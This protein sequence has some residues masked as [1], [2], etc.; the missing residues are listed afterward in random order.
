[1]ACTSRRPPS[2]SRTAALTDD[3]SVWPEPRRSTAQDGASGSI[4]R[5]ARRGGR[6]QK[7]ERPERWQGQDLEPTSALPVLGIVVI[8]VVEII[9]KVEE[10]VTV[11]RAI[12]TGSWSG[13][14][15]TIHDQ[16]CRC[17]AVGWPRPAL[18]QT[19]AGKQQDRQYCQNGLKAPGVVRGV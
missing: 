18:A 7:T 19:S 5:V 4:A 14:E 3:A 2:T 15:R 11:G 8:V 13:L 9:V 16:S 10:G 17:L 1:M 6:V 12:K